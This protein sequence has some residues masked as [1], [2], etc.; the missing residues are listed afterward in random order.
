MNVCCYFNQNLKLSC[1]LSFDRVRKGRRK[2]VEEREEE[3]K[4]LD[5]ISSFSHDTFKI[6]AG[7]AIGSSGR[8]IDAS[9]IFIDVYIL[10]V[11]P[12]GYVTW[13]KDFIDGIK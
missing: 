2:Q 11:G 13:Q 1:P 5:Y 6:P 8:K 12:C 9:P 10:F 3:E 7:L 4:P